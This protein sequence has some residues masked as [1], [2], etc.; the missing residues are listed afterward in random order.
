MI[1]ALAI[2]AALLIAAFVAA[3]ARAQDAATEVPA[4][5]A[6]P[7]VPA[8][9]DTSP[10]PTVP[11][12]GPPASAPAGTPPASDAADPVVP[13]NPPADTISDSPQS[14]QDTDHASARQPSHTGDGSGQS[15]AAPA[16]T[17][18]S[19]GG[20]TTTVDTL[21][22]DS[23]GYPGA[24]SGQD[25]FVVDKAPNRTTDAVGATGGPRGL[26]AGFFVF[27][28]S[29]RASNLEAKARRSHA[30]AQATEVGRTPGSGKHLPRH[31]LFFNLLSGSGGSAAGLALVSL[32][33]VLGAAFVL[34]RD[35]LRV[36]RMPMATWRPSAY[37]P[38]IELPG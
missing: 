35:R 29:S 31:N 33:A 36:F 38:P 15:N 1:R 5:E 2:A 20:D 22:S 16:P 34:P 9:T 8:T 13:D 27:H 17:V 4:A 10:P 19:M 24:W 25:T 3:P 21:A 18:P 23:D 28:P 12:P 37:V 7:P 14:T 11:D 26:L 6:T 32:L 30:V